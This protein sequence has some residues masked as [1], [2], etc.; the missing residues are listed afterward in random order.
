MPSYDYK[1][2]ECNYLYNEVRDSL[3]PQWITKCPICSGLL[4]ENN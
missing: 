1:C 3:D 2:E 4:K